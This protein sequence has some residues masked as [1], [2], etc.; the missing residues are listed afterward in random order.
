MQLSD[1]I[2]YNEGYLKQQTGDIEKI[3]IIRVKSQFF[4]ALEGVQAFN[5]KRGFKL[6]FKIL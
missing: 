6:K 2:F 3:K 1:T 5:I 4:V